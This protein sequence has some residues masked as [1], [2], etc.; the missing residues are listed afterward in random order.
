MFAPRDAADVHPKPELH[1]R[2]HVVG[3]ASREAIAKAVGVELRRMRVAAGLSS[4]EAAQLLGCGRRH[5]NHAESGLCSPRIDTLML[6]VHA[7]GG[8]LIEVERAIERALA[9]QEP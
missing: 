4:V 1:T 6:I 8:S 5:V 3:P 7:Y 9:G 2:T